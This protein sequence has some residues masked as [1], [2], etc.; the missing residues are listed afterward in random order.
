MLTRIYKLG[1]LELNAPTSLGIS[2][3]LLLVAF[4]VYR[5]HGKQTIADHMDNWRNAHG[6][7]ERMDAF[8][9]TNF[10]IKLK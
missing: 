3:G 9:S 5:Q 4:V 6:N 1:M 8:V 7:K 2:I 10:G